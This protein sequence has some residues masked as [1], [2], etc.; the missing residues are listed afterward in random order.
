M[1]SDWVFVQKKKTLILIDRQNEY[2]LMSEW[3]EKNGSIIEL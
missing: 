3:K 1:D 2:K